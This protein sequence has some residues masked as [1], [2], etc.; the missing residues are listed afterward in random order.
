[1]LNPAKLEYA[2]Q[3]VSATSLPRDTTAEESQFLG[4]TDRSFRPLANDNGQEVRA[5]LRAAKAM[6]SEF[7]MHLPVALRTGILAQSNMVMDPE[8]WEDDDPLPSLDS[9]RTMLRGLVA[10]S[11]QARPN[12][13]ISH[14]GSFVAGWFREKSKVVLDFQPNDR[15]RWL[16]VYQDDDQVSRAGGDES[17]SRLAEVISVHQGR[18]IIDGTL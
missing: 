4:G 13:A 17:V 18:A 8:D 7:S 10:I 14:A 15:C 11:P 12:M 2:P 5:T 1:M 9:Y 16:V 3:A 6:V